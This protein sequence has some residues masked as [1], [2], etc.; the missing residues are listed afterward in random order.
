MDLG[1]TL[2]FAFDTAGILLHDLFAAAS[3]LQLAQSLAP[4]LTNWCSPIICVA[5]TQALT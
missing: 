1:A 3:L 5:P 2:L 4:A